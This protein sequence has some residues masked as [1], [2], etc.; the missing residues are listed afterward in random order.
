MSS[1][2]S[3]RG[4]FGFHLSVL[5]LREAMKL[6]RVGQGEA[7]RFHHNV[8]SSP[9]YS[10]TRVD[11]IHFNC[12]F[13]P[14]SSRVSPTVVPP[15]HSLREPTTSAPRGATLGARIKRYRS[16]V[17]PLVHGRKN[18]HSPAHLYLSSSSTLATVAALRLQFRLRNHRFRV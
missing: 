9:F 1:E 18:P 13:P 14:P 8:I 15:L 16:L 11:S 2:T 10:S 4:I 17:M 12:S 7:A 5:S 3:E 6:R